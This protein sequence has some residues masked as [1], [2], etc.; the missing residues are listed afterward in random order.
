GMVAIG[1]LLDAQTWGSGAAI[2]SGFIRAGAAALIAGGLALRSR[3]A[4]WLGVV[5]LSLLL[6]AGTSTIVFMAATRGSL[7][8]VTPRAVLGWGALLLLV[9]ALALLARRTTREALG[10]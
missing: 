8:A 2:W 9:P 6:V 7:G 5:A 10:L 1:I 4:W 3:W